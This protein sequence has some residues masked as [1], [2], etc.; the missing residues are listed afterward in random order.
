MKRDGHEIGGVKLKPSLPIAFLACL[1]LV[2]TASAETFDAAAP[3]GEN[4]EQAEFRL[5]WW[6]WSI[7]LDCLC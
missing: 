7:F 4:Y 5:C 6:M 1:V 2:G 3:P